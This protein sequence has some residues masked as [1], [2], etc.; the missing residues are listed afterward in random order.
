VCGITVVIRSQ[1]NVPKKKSKN[2]LGKAVKEAAK[3][4]AKEAA[5]KG[6]QF[7]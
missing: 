2:P 3:K 4:A 5:K 6:H 1:Q 7:L